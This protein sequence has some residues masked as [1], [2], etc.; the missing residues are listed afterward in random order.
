M[1]RIADSHSDYLAYRVI[2]TEGVHLYNQSGIDKMQRGGVALQNLA[3]WSPADARD[4]VSCSLC[5]VSF[6]YHMLSC[7]P[8]QVHICTSPEHLSQPGIGFILSVES[9]ES[10]GCHTKLIPQFYNWGARILCLTWNA[11]N[12]F[13]SGA[14]SEG[15]IKPSGIEALRIMDELFMALDLSH[16]NEQGFWEALTEY[17]GAPCATH[18]CVYE[19][20]PNPR[21]LHKEQI[22]AIVDRKGYIGVNFFTE[23]LT[24]RDATVEDVLDH[25]EY[26]L[27]CGGEDAVGL[28][29]DYC[30]MP[31]APDGLLTAAEFQNVPL[32][33]ERRGYSPELIDK[34][35]Y[36]NF[37]R[38]IIQF[39]KHSLDESI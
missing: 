35:C 14:L 25:I 38:Y 19:L 17:R 34:I 1:I 27:R 4:C 36:G 7:F 32:A 18:S 21:N 6:L 8:S 30:G 23:F 29:S 9:G 20:C 31:S 39:L 12:A 26:I 13:A 22:E 37:A 10:I 16:I 3:V 33:M 11:E 28:G 5:Q 24:G 2:G 15:G